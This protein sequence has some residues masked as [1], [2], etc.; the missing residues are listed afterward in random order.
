MKK[1]IFIYYNGEGDSSVSMEKITEDWGKWF[2]QIGDKLVDGGA[3]LASGGMSVTGG[4]VSEI[5]ADMWPATGYSLVN[6]ESME[7]AVEIAKGC[8]AHEHTDGKAAVRVYE[9]TPM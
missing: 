7:D 3:P 6:A 5:P 2:G 4:E 8:P 9:V 1:F